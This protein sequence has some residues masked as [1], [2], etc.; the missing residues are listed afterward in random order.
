MA[1]VVEVRRHDMPGGGVIATFT[2]I[3]ERKRAE[4]ELREAKEAAERANQAKAAFL[5]AV[6]HELRTPLN[7]ILGFSE[8]M[9]AELFGPFENE[10]YLGYIRDIH[11]SGSHL[12]NLINDIL[13]MSKADA[14]RID[15]EEK[16]VDVAAAIG[17]A[18]KMVRKRADN[19]GPSPLSRKPLPACR[20]FMPMNGGCVRFF[21]TCCPTRSNSPTTM[22]KWW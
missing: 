1:T 3:T 20:A 18:V 21:S 22:A 17:W 6:S 8:A 2:G 9:L 13:D 5:A 11:D 19:A 14:G 4:L 10:H 12:H 16:A 15:L 7:A